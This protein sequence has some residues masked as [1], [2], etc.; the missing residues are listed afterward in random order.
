MEWIPE[1]SPRTFGN[2]VLF[3]DVFK[4]Y[5]CSGVL[6]I[7]ESAYLTLSFSSPVESILV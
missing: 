5:V 3:S 1:L 7:V 6:M 4:L 2:T